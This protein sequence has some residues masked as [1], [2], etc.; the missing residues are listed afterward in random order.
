M[1]TPQ[2]LIRSSLVAFALL[3]ALPVGAGVNR[4][5]SLGPRSDA[6]VNA[7][8]RDASL[9]DTVYAATAGGGVFK[10]KDGGE[11][12]APVNTGLDDGYV[13][14]LAVDPTAAGTVYAATTFAGI[15][16]TMDGAETWTRT[17]ESIATVDFTSLAVDP[18]RSSRVYAGTDTGVVYG[19]A[20]GGKTWAQLLVIAP[21]PPGYQTGVSTLAVD[22]ASA[23]YASAHSSPVYRSLDAGK[24]WLPINVGAT[25]YYGYTPVAADATDSNTVYIGLD[26]T[27]YKTA[28]GG[29]TWKATGP[30]ITS[31][32]ITTIALSPDDPNT[33]VLGTYGNGK[34]YLSR[35]AAT[36]WTNLTD[37]ESDS[38]K[39]IRALLVGG[40]PSPEILAALGATVLKGSTERDSLPWRAVTAGLDA[41]IA[42]T[43]AASPSDPS[44]LLA[45]DGVHAIRSSDAGETWSTADSAI[46]AG[47]FN[48]A[49]SPANPSTA[50]AGTSS[51]ILRTEDGGAS[52]QRTA[53]GTRNNSTS[54]FAFSATSPDTVYAATSSGVQKSIDA[55]RR[56]TLTGQR[57]S[58]Y[59]VLADRLNASVV[60]AVYLPGYLYYGPFTPTV[61]K[62]ADAGVTWKAADAGLPGTGIATV[63]M[64]SADTQTLYAGTFDK[65]VYKTTDGG[66]SWKPA[67]AGI[68]RAHVQSIAANPADSETL[69][70]ATDR[71]VFRSGDAAAS[72]LPFNDGLANLSVTALSIDSSGRH[73]YASTTG[74]G[75]LGMEIQPVGSPCE[76]AEGRVCYLGRFLVSASARPPSGN[77][78]PLP[79]VV[80]QGDRFGSFRLGLAGVAAPDIFIK[81]VDGRSLPGSAFWVFH[82]G[83]TNDDYTLT[84]TDTAT[85]RVRV[86][87]NGADRPGCGGIDTLAFSDF[88][89]AA[90]AAAP[91]SALAPGDGD[92]LAL[93][94]SRYSV[95]LSATD[96]RSGQ[97]ASGLAM[98]QGDRDGYF[99]LPGFTGDPAFPEVFVRISEGQD[100]SLSFTHTG[101]TDLAYVLTVTDSSTGAVATY[102]ND[103]SDSL[104]PCGGSAIL[105]R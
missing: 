94:H 100:G 85:G 6:V 50:L 78:P 46:P 59:G 3:A 45:S 92:T 93:Y 18:G 29:E 47:F 60:Y 22:G 74:G 54:G 7:L 25:A 27:L 28:D 39:S 103:T 20:D 63:A 44:N 69:Y 64:D 31:G 42:T 37:L 70:A 1:K 10:S 77:L 65:G 23:V 58:A 79:V 17:S 15:F 88:G 104:R 2:S 96:P 24:T 76:E 62:S 33:I 53:L 90:A 101:L 87:Q 83:L 41:A 13:T 11:T 105:R 51:G 8:A 38:G 52:W 55:G 89:S 97:T 21:P 36:T 12:W 26:R 86:Y 32:G 19:T 56:W 48:F 5:T 71:G 16:K 82:A 9:P 84:V 30:S 40:Q 72:W 4:W 80:R 66:S 67:N 73:L 81:I 61:A 75:I 99:S 102:T 95:S 49:Y 14:A 68:E 34:A 43:V 57:D 35:D 98:P 91:A